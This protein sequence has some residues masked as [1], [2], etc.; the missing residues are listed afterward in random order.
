MEDGQIMKHQLSA[1]SVHSWCSL[2]S[3]RLN[4]FMEADH[5]G[6]A[7]CSTTSYLN[8]W[9][10]INFYIIMKVTGVMTQGRNDIYA[11]HNQWVTKYRVQ[12]SS[13]TKE[14]L[15]IQTSDNTGD[16]VFEGNRDRDTIVTNVFSTPVQTNLIRIVPIE[17]HG[18]I[19]LRF[20]LLGCEDSCVDY[21]VEDPL[22]TSSCSECYIGQYC[23]EVRPGLP[24]ALG[25]EDGAIANSQITSSPGYYYDFRP[26]NARL[27]GPS[28][29]SGELRE[30]MWIQIDLLSEVIV[31]RIQTQGDVYN[32]YYVKTLAIET[33][34]DASSLTPI[35][36][37]GSN[38]T[39][40]FT[41]NKNNHEVVNIPLPKPIATRYVRI[42]VKS[43]N[44]YAPLRLEVI[45]YECTC[46]Y[47]LTDG[48]CAKG[49][50]TY[51]EL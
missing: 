20:E 9:I 35:M 7:W 40:I 2:E 5:T 31:S 38:I 3:A 37:A 47:G 16:E 28:H 8:Q 45:G 39:K 26:N 17:W 51:F 49:M 48:Y 29:W 27:N 12:H 15:Y 41:A 46:P 18:H 25:M 6:G 4:S 14:W 33:G 34:F 21:E 23:N 36:D 32:N 19:S 50:C 10:Q 22:E 11:D 24:K 43:Y 13:D 44:I 1:S 42:V 30:Y